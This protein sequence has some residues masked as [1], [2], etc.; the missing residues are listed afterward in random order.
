PPPPAAP[1]P[2]HALTKRKVVIVDKDGKTRSWEGGPNDTPPAWALEPPAPPA[3][4][5]PPA[6]PAEDD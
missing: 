3:P 5:T 1:L 4:P 2:L 6:P